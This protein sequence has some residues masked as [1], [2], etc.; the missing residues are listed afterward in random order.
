MFDSI[1]TTLSHSL[2]ATAAAAVALLSSAGAAR[3]LLLLPLGV[4]EEIFADE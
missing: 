3:T 2:G 4:W 1:L